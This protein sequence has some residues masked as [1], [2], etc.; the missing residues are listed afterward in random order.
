[1][2]RELTRRQAIA[3][4]GTTVAL[5]GT[6]TTVSGETTDAVVE[7]GF[8]TE[9]PKCV[10]KMSEGEWNVSMPINVHVRVPGDT[11]ALAAVEDEFTGLSDL[12]WTR[13]LPDSP[14]R[15]W[16]ERDEKLIAPSLS[17][18]RPRLGDEWPH[19][20]VWEV[21]A[22]RVALHAHLDVLDFGSSHLHRGDYYREA[23]ER[24]DDQFTADGWERDDS[25]DIEYGVDPERLEGWG[26][27][28]DLKLEYSG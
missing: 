13:L 9:Y 11:L 22:D 15:A 16:D 6:A 2:A 18:R 4:I 12:E 8:E 28:G 7:T 24:V 19:V 10:Y 5:S 20:H 14:T 21:D 26:E 27:T 1:M 3:G 25:H 23:V 17:F